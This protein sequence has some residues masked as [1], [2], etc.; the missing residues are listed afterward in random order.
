MQR[1]DSTYSLAFA[2]RRTRFVRGL[3]LR[4]TERRPPFL[5]ARTTLRGGGLP[6]RSFLFFLLAP[7][8]LLALTE[9]T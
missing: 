2:S 5:R 1:C 7:S 6:M 9:Y 4:A 8:K 3:A